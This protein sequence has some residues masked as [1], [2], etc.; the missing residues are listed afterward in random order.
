[1][2]LLAFNAR[3]RREVVAQRPLAQL[4]TLRIG[5]PAEFYL[6]ARGFR[7]VIDAAEACKR[8]GLPMHILGG[9]SNLLID[10]AGVPGIVLNL[11]QMKRIVP[12]QNRLA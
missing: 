3:V 5:G 8:S 11:K 1:M 4:T 12:T 6:E 7:D 2:S 9:G 10:D